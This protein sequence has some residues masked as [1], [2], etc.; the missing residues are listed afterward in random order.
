MSV[1]KVIKKAAKIVLGK[2]GGIKPRKKPKTSLKDK[3]LN[4]TGTNPETIKTYKNGKRTATPSRG[5]RKTPGGKPQSNMGYDALSVAD[6]RSQFKGAGKVAYAGTAA[7]ITSAAYDKFNNKEKTG[8]ATAFRKANKA[9]KKTFTFSG[10]K[11]HTQLKNTPRTK[12][13]PPRK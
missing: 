12:P 13:T 6:N 4:I 10:K 2:K 5:I 9:N 7:F 1:T 11:Y 8:F 3:I